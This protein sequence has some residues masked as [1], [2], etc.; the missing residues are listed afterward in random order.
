MHH[1]PS[2]LR[3]AFIATLGLAMGALL[4]ACGGSDKP[5]NQPPVPTISSPTAGTLFRA[6]DTLSFSGGATDAEDGTLGTAALA[7]W[8]D[9]HHDDHTHPFRLLTAGASGTVTIPTRGETSDNIF[10]RFTLRATDSAGRVVEVTRDILPRKARVTL[11]TAPAG[12][13]LTLDGQAVTGPTPFTGVT[14]M[15]RDLG[16]PDQELGGRRYRFSSWSQ[17]GAATQTISTPGSDTTYTASFTDIG[18]VNN[19]PPSVTLAAP[20]TGTVGVAVTLNATASDTDGT[21]ARVDFFDGSTLI[22]TDNSSPYSVSWTPAT[23]GNRSLT[24]RATD[25]IGAQTTSTATVVA[26]AAANV[27][28]TVTISAP[29]TATTG[30]AVTLSASAADS[31]GSVASVQFFENGV[32]IGTDTTAPYSVSWTPATVGSRSLTARATDNRGATTTSAAATVDVAAPGNVPPTVSI[33]APTTATVGTPVTL[34]ATAG[35]TDGSVAS[36]QF[37]ENG[38]SIGTDTTSPYSTSWTPA[39]AGSR[40]LTARA[41][42]NLG[43][44]TTSSAAA[45][46][47]SPA[48]GPD[49]QNPTAA[50]SAPANFADNVTGTLTITATA[51]DNVGV[52][53]VEFQIDG[54]ALGSEDST[55]PYST[56]V[57]TLLYASGQH[58]VRA[59]ARDAAGNRSAWATAT[60]RFGGSRGI[61]SG[62]TKNEGW[63]TGLSSATAIAQAPDGRMF[64]AEQGGALRVVKNDALLATPFVSLNVDPNGERGLI[65]VTLHPNFASNGWVYVYYTR[66]NGG[67]RNNRISRFVAN[68][69]VSTGTETVLVDLPDLSAATNHN[70]GAMKFASDGKL[71]VAVGDN[72]NSATPQ[73]LADPFGKMLRFNDDGSVPGDNPNFG[74]QTGLARA[75]WAWGL[76]NPFTFAIQPGTGRMH[77]N[78]V[79]QNTWEEVNL[80]AA[81]ANYGWPGSEGPDNITAGVTA[82]LFPYRHSAASPAGSGPGGFFTGFAIAGGAFYPNSGPFPTGYRGNYFFADYVSRFVGVLDLANGNAAYAFATVGGSPVDLLTGVDGALYVLTRSS[83]TRIT[84]P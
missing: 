9:L 2:A 77:I 75:V 69:D 39:S 66:I 31:D 76:R 8:A 83:I 38:V 18:P 67:A 54:V 20:G 59:R 48:A 44:T 6:G 7:W 14:G 78:D 80:G 5:D 71:I 27:P 65:G 57:D 51:N 68:G 30:V 29:A 41:T 10:Y 72:A 74:T 32:S 55:A 84:A 1:D 17:G 82:P 46:T 42:D 64:I 47:V 58:V 79:G 21:V 49:A 34:T 45:V 3:R 62:F 28:P 4:A 19:Q 40:S 37:F 24:A 23:A 70:G 60:V 12:L 11:A 36:V 43:A 25:D 22:G 16:A 53:G 50:L 56:T 35:D 13:Q 81:G 61:P 33:G 63:I 26:V 52:A 15:E 73:N